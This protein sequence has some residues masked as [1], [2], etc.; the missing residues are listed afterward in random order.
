MPSWADHIR[1]GQLTVK[2]AKANP[3]QA[4][5]MAL[6]AQRTKLKGGDLESAAGAIATAIQESAVTNINYGDRD[7]LG[8]YQQR[9]SMGW[10][11]AAQVTNPT[12]AIDK[13]LSIY[14][15]YRRQGLGWLTA[16]HKTQRS[17]FASAPAKWYGES[18]RAAR[19]FLGSGADTSAV[20]G[21]GGGDGGGGST[22]ETRD[23]PYEF[24]RGSADKKEDSWT[25]IGR[26]AA[27]VGWRRFTANGELWLVSDQ[28]LVARQPKYRISEGARGV[29]GLS[30]EFETRQEST[31]AT[32]RTVIGRYG[33]SPGDVVQIAQEGPADGKWLVATTRRDLYSAVQ[34]TTLRRAQPKLPEPAPERETVTVNVAG[35]DVP[36]A[37]A[38]LGSINNQAARVYRAAE[39]A[40][41]HNWR[42]S[43]AQRNSQRPG[44]FADCS[45]GVSW[46]LSQAG[47]PIPG[48]MSPNAPVSGSYLS[49]G[50]AG[51]GKF[52]TIYTNSGHIW[53]RWNGIGNAWRFD[54]SGY[55]DR[56]TASSGGRNRSTPRPTGS[57]V[58]RHWAGL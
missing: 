47:V 39:V 2:G 7:S 17:A 27:E 52:F 57:F 24:S 33:L 19:Y 9:P 22:T 41:S 15:P 8:L 20:T 45:S 23:K 1:L 43:Q 4:Q 21:T 13:F 44:G 58:A 51:P 3:H 25:C 42:Y 6:I 48:A 14:L 11:T 10:G 46:V 40:T 38:D 56:Y 34:E 49:W 26:L 16:S 55:G 50:Q 18:L 30:F 32:L 53:I 36:R 12:Y 31:E 35:N 29:L 5:N 37:N 28:W 54:T